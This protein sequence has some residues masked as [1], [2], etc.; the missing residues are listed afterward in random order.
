M[1]ILL[2]FIL[3]MIIIFIIPI[4]LKIMV[5]YDKDS[6]YIQIYKFKFFPL[7]SIKEKN[8]KDEV[9]KKPPANNKIKPKKKKCRRKKVKKKLDFSELYYCLSHNPAKIKLKLDGIIEYSLGD[10]AYTAESYGVLQM[11]NPIIYHLLAFL[12]CIP[13]Y[14]MN[15]C[16]QF[17]DY[18]FIDLTINCIF[19]FNLAK[20]IYILIS[21]LAS[22][23]KI[24][25]VPLK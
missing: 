1:R 8:K 22:R 10:A 7:E 21:I 20:I 9:K 13:K 24:E 25:E 19:N 11:I 2:Y 12:F 4:R 14:E 6:F 18:L 5:H 3:F 15:F 16:P 23:K 17:K